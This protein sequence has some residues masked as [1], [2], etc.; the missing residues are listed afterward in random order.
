MGELR[1]KGT[2]LRRRQIEQAW[3]LGVSSDGSWNDATGR[4]QN[5][6]ERSWQGRMKG[7]VRG[8]REYEGECGGCLPALTMRPASIWHKR[9]PQPARRSALGDPMR[10]EEGGRAADVGAE[11]TAT[12]HKVRGRSDPTA[13]QRHYSASTTIR[14]L[15]IQ[16]YP[17]CTALN[18]KNANYGRQ[19]QSI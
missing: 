5:D 6:G 2:I 10:T 4:G 11:S 18:P 17:T 3:Y 19:T 16:V 8:Q 9:I 13:N 12:T 15:L 7:S 1:D 14:K